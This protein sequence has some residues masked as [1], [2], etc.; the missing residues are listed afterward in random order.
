MASAGLLASW[1]TALGS[2]CLYNTEIEPKCHNK[3]KKE[4]EG[5][6]EKEVRRR[7]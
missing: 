4:R 5:E 2:G 1:V 7:W 6:E 3:S